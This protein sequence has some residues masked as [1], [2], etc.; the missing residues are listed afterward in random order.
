MSGTIPPLLRY[1]FMAWC[2]VKK[3]H[4]DSYYFKFYLHVIPRTR[5]P[6]FDLCSET[7]Q[8]SVLPFKPHGLSQ[9]GKKENP[10]NNTRH[11]V[12]PVSTRVSFPGGE[13][14]QGLKLTT[15]LHL[16]PRPN[17]GSYTSS[18]QYAFMALCLVKHRDNFTYIFNE[19]C[20]C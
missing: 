9:K 7:S 15:H 6:I 17:E 12:C 5:V 18:P 14:V 11:E 3:K 16:V 10:C 20:S 8:N 19:V 4:R 1:A 13:S 2:L